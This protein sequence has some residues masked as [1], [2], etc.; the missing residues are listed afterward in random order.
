MLITVERYR[1]KQDFTDPADNDDATVLSR[2]ET[3]QRITDPE[4]R[5]SEAEQKNTYNAAGSVVS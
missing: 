5:N 1:K 4:Q 2:I 3:D